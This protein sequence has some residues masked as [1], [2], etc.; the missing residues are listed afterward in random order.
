MELN[1]L[2]LIDKMALQHLQSKK[3]EASFSHYDIWLDQH[4]YAFTVAKMMDEDLLAETRQA[5]ADALANGTSFREFKQ[6]LKPFLM[7]RGWWGEQMMIDPM[8]DEP[9]MVQLGST[10]RLK[11]IFQTNIATAHASARWQRIQANKRGLPYLR[12]NAS[13]AQHQRD[14]H[15]RY[16]GLVLP[17]EHPIWQQIFPP[18][19]YGCKCSVTQLTR[20]QAERAGISEEPNFEF[21]EVENPRTGE[22]VRVPRDIE[23]SFAHNHVN[24]QKAVLDLASDKHGESFGKELAQDSQKHVDARVVQPKIA[25]MFTGNVQFAPMT[26]DTFSLGNKVLNK[27]TIA[28]LSGAVAESVLTITEWETDDFQALRIKISND[29]IYNPPAKV[30]LKSDKNNHLTLVVDLQMIQPDM[31][32]KGISAFALRQQVRMAKWLGVE[33]LT[34]FAIGD[35]NDPKHHGYYAWARLGFNAEIPNSLREKLP[36]QLKSAQELADLMETQQGREWWRQHGSDI[37]VKFDLSSGSKSLKILRKYLFEK[38]WA[39]L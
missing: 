23:P 27:E 10:R 9:K 7:S 13:H 14:A 16:Y 8:D 2:G 22:V 25:Q 39:N 38:F 1:P 5:L 32:G 26:E 28:L 15:K 35:I 17:V 11:T 36:E 31:Q 19:G 24:R 34:A 6:R 3:L 37:A 4:A 29:N 21:V 18:N 33:N 12:Y 20:G 30:V